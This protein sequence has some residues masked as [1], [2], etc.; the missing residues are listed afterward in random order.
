MTGAFMEILF[1]G[2]GAAVPSRNRS[3]SCIAVRSGS[4]IV[5]MDCGEGSQRQIMISPYSFMKIRAILITHMHGDHIL[6]LPG[7]IQTMS[8]EG[9]KSPLC[10]YGPPGFRE[11][12]D[13]LMRAT[14]GSTVFDL[15]VK[16]VVPGDSFPAG[17][18]K[19]GV[20]QVNHGVPA[21]G[22][23][24]S[25]PDR[26]GKL[27][28]DKAVSLGIRDGPDMARLKNGET[29]NGVRPEQV[30][31][32]PVRGTRVV[33]TGDTASV[34]S[35]AEAS[36]GA[37]VLIHE[38]T[39]SGEDRELAGEHFHSTAGEAAETALRAGAGTL[40][41]THVS[42]RY[43]S[44]RDAVLKEAGSVFPDVFLA[45]DFDL[46]EITK[47]GAVMK[48]PQGRETAPADRTESE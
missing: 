11:S 44:S 20:F 32:P 35:V 13:M 4:D 10:V 14:G 18:M 33:Y 41:L 34:P 38:A 22:Y 47:N 25:E 24:V 27:D 6:G 16:E 36:R 26:P 5:L 48:S 1:L 15:Y 30:V 40:I 8:L 37:D 39:Y 9:R 7:L 17:N 3:T 28:R 12:L 31:G 2:T 42:N 29:V 45:D 43:D 19:V 21:V 46:F 23:S